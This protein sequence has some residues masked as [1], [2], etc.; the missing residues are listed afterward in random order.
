LN[1]PTFSRQ[2]RVAGTGACASIGYLNSGPIR[3]RVSDLRIEQAD[4]DGPLRDWQHIHNV[5][6]PDVIIPAA[7]LSLDDP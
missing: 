6:I 5:I 4:G 7:V 1:R 2:E 3:E